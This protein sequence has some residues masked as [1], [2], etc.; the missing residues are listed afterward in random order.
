[1]N[2]F[3]FFRVN[4]EDEIPINNDGKIKQKMNVANM[5][6]YCSSS[7]IL[8]NSTKGTNFFFFFFFN[9]LLLFMV[10]CLDVCFF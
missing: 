7:P 8:L 6:L 2:F 3:F 10:F 1:L 4:L 9:H 5:Y